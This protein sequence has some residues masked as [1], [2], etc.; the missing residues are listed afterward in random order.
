MKHLNFLEFTSGFSIFGD[1]LP[2]CRYLYTYL[3]IL[4]VSCCIGPI[5]YFPAVTLLWIPASPTECWLTVFFSLT[6]FPS[7]IY[8]LLSFCSNMC[9]FGMGLICLFLLPF[10]V[11]DSKQEYSFFFNVLLV[12]SDAYLI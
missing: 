5:Q 6:Y 8:S 10:P 9:W 3:R 12:S 7:F 2:S 1:G 11:L 4:P